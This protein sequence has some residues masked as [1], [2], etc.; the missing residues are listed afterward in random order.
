MGTKLGF[1]S[2]V[3]ATVFFMSACGASEQPISATTSAVVGES[4]I[5]LTMPTEPIY[6]GSYAY[7][8]VA[9]AP[10]SPLTLE[11]FIFRIDSG[12]AGGAVSLSADD[13][14]TSQS[15]TLAAGGETGLHHLEVLAR[16]S[17]ELVASAPFELTN[18]WYD[19]DVGPSMW[20]SGERRP[21]PEGAAWGGGDQGIQN[22]EVLPIKGIYNVGIILVD[23]ATS[24]YDATSGR[25]TKESWVGEMGTLADYFKEASGERLHVVSEYVG[26]VNLPKSFNRYF[27]PSEGYAPRQDFYR[28]AVSAAVNSGFDLTKYQSVFFVSKS[29]SSTQWAWPV[30][31]VGR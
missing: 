17:G 26:L 23:T 18:E 19:E 24:R 5:M 4:P 6:V 14:Q 2:A 25:L 31:T 12:L 9:I 27:N 13:Y 29:P 11:D 16:A 22:V 20:L 28:T 8:P 1:A 7:I 10:T 21:E 30:A 3:V 15:I